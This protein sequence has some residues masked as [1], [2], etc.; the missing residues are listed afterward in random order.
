MA[1]VTLR[2]QLYLIATIPRVYGTWQSTST[3]AKTGAAGYDI[4]HAYNL[5]NPRQLATLHHGYGPELEDEEAY[6]N[7]L[8]HPVNVT[9]ECIS[10]EGDVARFFGRYFSLLIVRAFELEERAEVGPIVGPYP[11]TVDMRFAYGEKVVAVVEFKR[12]SIRREE[13][14]MNENTNPKRNLSQ[15]I[16]MYGSDHTTQVRHG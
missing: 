6:L 1:Y 7:K 11:N 15:E 10:S 12:P 13:W 16:R 4:I 9:T 14:Q 8:V 3:N 2:S 5:I